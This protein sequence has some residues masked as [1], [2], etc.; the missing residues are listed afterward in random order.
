MS[1]ETQYL[2][3]MFMR[4]A[5]PEFVNT[6]NNSSEVWRIAEE[7]RAWTSDAVR[8]VSNQTRVYYPYL[9][10]PTALFSFGTIQPRGAASTLACIAAPLLLWCTLTVF[11]A[12]FFRGRGKSTVAVWLIAVA[13]CQIWWRGVT[14]PLIAVIVLVKLALFLC[15]LPD[16]M[17]A[18]LALVPDVDDI[19]DDIDS[20]CEQRSPVQYAS[21][22]GHIA[23]AAVQHNLEGGAIIVSVAE[24]E[25]R[26]E[27]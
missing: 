17:T 8:F 16:E 22:Q 27:Q 24:N 4:D 7:A 3:E 10:A 21:G 23:D 11:T 25:E 1:D 14:L 9:A 15:I 13:A 18:L 20:S 19:L 26:V 12:G 6:T 5:W 2:Y